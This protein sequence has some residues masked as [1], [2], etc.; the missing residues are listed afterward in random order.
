MCSIKWKASHTCVAIQNS[1]SYL[2]N[3]GCDE[4]FVALVKVKAIW[5][6]I[7]P[8]Q[9]PL[10]ITKLERGLKSYVTSTC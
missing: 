2:Q 3:W 5:D 6:T 9:G 10:Q 1:V 8:C 4:F 7:V